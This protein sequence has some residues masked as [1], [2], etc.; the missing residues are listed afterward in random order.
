MVSTHLKNISQNGS[1]PQVGVKI[2]DNWNHHPVFFLR[3]TMTETVLMPYSAI[4][5]TAAW[6]NLTSQLPVLY[7]GYLYLYEST[8]SKYPWTSSTLKPWKTKV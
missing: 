7:T 8:K 1:F 6:K 3:Y 2:K 4:F 5:P